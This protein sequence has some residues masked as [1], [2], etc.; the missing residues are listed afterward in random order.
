MLFPTKVDFFNAVQP[1]KKVV[2]VDQ[3]RHFGSLC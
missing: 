2:P 3:S 1:I